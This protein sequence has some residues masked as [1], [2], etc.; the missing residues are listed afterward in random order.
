M[1]LQ[2]YSLF[3]FV[4][5]QPHLIDRWITF[6]PM[7]CLKYGFPLTWESCSRTQ[8]SGSISSLWHK[9]I[10][11]AA[12][13][14]KLNAVI[15]FYV[16]VV[17]LKDEVC[18]VMLLLLFKI[19]FPC[20]VC[21][22]SFVSG[23]EMKVSCQGF[24]WNSSKIQQLAH[25]LIFASLIYM[26]MSEVLVSRRTAAVVE[27]APT[28]PVVTVHVLWPQLKTCGRTSGLTLGVGRNNVRD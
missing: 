23:I 1:H 27:V 21:H 25:C 7:L 11:I 9:C 16:L 20:V 2:L 5:W 13:F 10:W 14:A 3:T 17:I 22:I 12:N 26:V 19:S 6:H 24:L 8:D 15:I 28:C 4:F 18:W